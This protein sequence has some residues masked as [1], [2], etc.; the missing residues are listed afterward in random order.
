MAETRSGFLTLS[1]Q[2]VDRARAAGLGVVAGEAGSETWQA[3][4]Q[5]VLAA[6]LLEQRWRALLR[7]MDSSCS[8]A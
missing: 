7:G 5:A 4:Q 3:W 2:A 1:E 8:G 6:D